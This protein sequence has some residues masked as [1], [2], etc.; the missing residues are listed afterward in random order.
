MINRQ[1]EL[2]FASQPGIKRAG[3]CRRRSSRA[4][5]WFERMRGVVDE[6]ADALHERDHPLSSRF[7]SRLSRE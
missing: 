1:L 4:N 6:V 3:R 5:W 2:G 7:P